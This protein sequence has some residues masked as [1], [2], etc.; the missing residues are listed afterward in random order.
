MNSVGEDMR[1]GRFIVFEGPDGSGKTTQQKLV[2]SAV[3]SAICECEPTGGEIGRQIRRALGGEVDCAPETLALLFAADRCEH[4]RTLEALLE[5]GQTVLCD[6]YVFSSI[7]YQGL[8]L[9]VDWIAGINRRAT[10]RLL[11]DAVVYIDLPTESCMDRIARGREHTEIFETT[12]RIAK[13][14]ENYERAFAMFPK[15]KL[16]RIDGAQPMDAVTSD[17]LAHLRSEGLI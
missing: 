17:I 16:I 7:A 9:D 10:E 6:R 1:G 8:E 2:A 14:R 13:V 11:P 5:K 12:E 4:V 15:L 3:G